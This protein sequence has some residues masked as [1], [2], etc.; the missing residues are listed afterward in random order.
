MRNKNEKGDWCEFCESKV[1]HRLVR[2]SFHFKGQTIYVEN[3]PAWVCARCQEKYFDTA[4]YKRLEAIAL[5]RGHIG[6]TVRF[7]L[8]DYDKILNI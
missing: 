4:V 5:H 1:E 6:K 3:V 8:A 7:P 2:A